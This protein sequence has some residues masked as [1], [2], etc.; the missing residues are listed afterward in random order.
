MI[1]NEIYSIQYLR[2]IAALMVVLLHVRV[3]L[4]RMGYGGYWPEFL[5]AGVDIFFVISGFIMWVT[6][7]DGST[8]PWQFL[9]RRFVRII[10]VYWLLTTTTVAVMLVA[11]S[12]VQSGRFDSIHVLSSYLFIPTVHPLTGMM[13]PVL[14]P[15]WTLNYEMFFYIIFEIG[16]AHV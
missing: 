10:P 1:A 12:A 13:E 15:G 14:I 6:T 3:Q 7:F 2:G 9:F 8:T 4:G 11:P 16:R 5:M